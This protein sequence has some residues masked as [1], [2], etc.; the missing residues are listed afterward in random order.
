MSPED[1]AKDWLERR[2]PRPI[3]NP[4][5]CPVCERF[6]LGWDAS[7]KHF[8]ECLLLH[9]RGEPSFGKLTRVAAPS[10]ASPGPRSPR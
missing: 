2:R 4:V 3:R 9:I 8:V 7:G 6:H 10:V 5:L 1:A